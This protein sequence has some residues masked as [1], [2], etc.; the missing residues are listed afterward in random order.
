MSDGEKSILQA[1]I[2]RDSVED[3]TKD[4]SNWSKSFLKKHKYK[5]RIN[6]NNNNNNNNNINKLF[7]I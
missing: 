1:N 7:I 4:L 2:N 3:K 6:N 5:V